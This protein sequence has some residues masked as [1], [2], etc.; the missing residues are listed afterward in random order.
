MINRLKYV[1]IATL[2]FCIVYLINDYNDNGFDSEPFA[3]LVI[4]IGS[5]LALFKK[6]KFISIVK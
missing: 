5:G 2:A 4:T 3:F 6:N 1:W